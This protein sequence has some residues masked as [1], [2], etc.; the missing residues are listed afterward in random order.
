MKTIK[1][2]Y[3]SNKKIK[4]EHA[5]YNVL[6]GER[7]NGK[8]YQILYEIVE[9]YLVKNKKGAIIRRW[10]T[11]FSG[12]QGAGTCYNSLIENGKGVNVINELSGGQFNTVVYRGMCYYLATITDDGDI[13][14]EK[15]PF[16]YGFAITKAEHYKMLALPMITTILFD[17]FLT[18]QNYLP[19]E[20][21][22]F[23]SIVSSIIRKRDDVTIWLCGNT[24]NQYSPYFREM[25]ITKI[26]DMKQGTID[27]YRYGESD[28]KV[29]VEY[30]ES[31]NKKNKKKSD[32][33]FAFDNPTLD[34]IKSGTWEFALYPKCPTKFRP[35]DIRLIYFINFSDVILQ[36][37]IVK[38]EE[39]NFTY[40]HEKTTPIKNEN[41]IV[42]SLEISP[43]P[44]KYKNILKG[45]DK[46]SKIITNYYM[47]DQVYYQDNTVGELMRNYLNECKR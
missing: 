26:K 45:I 7:S 14:K 8:T 1:N 37:E 6:F 19:H 15:D 24:V 17:E 28:L 25:G 33:Y 29:A 32:V 13:E 35:K 22:D 2:E 4:E 11:D 27:V 10:E 38:S 44:Y 21:E 47:I 9:N 23:C 30:C 12:Q 42:Y 39:F 46:V 20:F 34:M 43:R 41:D 3:Y 31:T 18:R 5:H 16:C 40:I 36:C